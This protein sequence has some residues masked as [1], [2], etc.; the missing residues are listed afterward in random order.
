METKKRTVIKALSYRAL[1]SAILAAISWAF[2]ASVDQT[3]VITMLYAAL[4]T[5][6]YYGHERIWNRVAWGTKRAIGANSF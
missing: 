5:V 6:G 4:A 3:V 1:V 2:T